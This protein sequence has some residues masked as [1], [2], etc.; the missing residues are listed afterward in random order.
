M[1]NNLFMRI[2]K[3]E[4]AKNLEEISKNFQNRCPEIIKDISNILIFLSIYCGNNSIKIENINLEIKK[5]EVKIIRNDKGEKA[6]RFIVESYDQVQKLECIFS[7]Y[8]IKVENKTDNDFSYYIVEY[9]FDSKGN[10]TRKAKQ[11]S[12]PIDKELMLE[13]SSEGDKINGIYYS[14]ICEKNSNMNFLFIKILNENKMQNI[15]Y[16]YH[17]DPNYKLFYKVPKKYTKIPCINKYG[18]DDLTNFISRTNDYVKFDDINLF[19][20]LVKI[21]RVYYKK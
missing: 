8:Y 12:T 13:E 11:K 5:N 7:K 20:D 14:E 21:C 1:H 19:N 17:I 2:S 15:Y 4:F 18:I 6:Q 10:F 3:Q 16:S 9:V